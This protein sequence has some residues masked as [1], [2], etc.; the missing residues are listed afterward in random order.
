MPPRFRTI[1]HLLAHQEEMDMNTM[2]ETNVCYGVN[3]APQPKN[4]KQPA[5]FSEEE[6][7]RSTLKYLYASGALRRVK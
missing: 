4:S 5:Y 2:S 6:R 7:W 1:A 3:R